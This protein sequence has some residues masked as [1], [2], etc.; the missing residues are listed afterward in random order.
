MKA[1]KIFSE[2]RY[3]AT[4]SF[5]SMTHSSKPFI[6]LATIFLANF[7]ANGLLRAQKPP[8]PPPT[9]NIKSIFPR[10]GQPGT[11]FEVTFQGKNLEH[12]HALWFDCGALRARFLRVEALQPEARPGEV[13]KR[14]KEKEGP[15]SYH[16][17]F[18]VEVGEGARIGAHAL[19][20][21]SSGGVSNPLV[22]QVNSEP[23]IL[24]QDGPHQ[25]PQQAQEIPFFP[26]VVNGRVAE[27][28]ELDYYSIRVSKGQDLLFEVLP[29]TG[30]LPTNFGNF[31]PRVLL[32]EPTGSWF[33]PHQPTWLEC[34]DES[35]FYLRKGRYTIQYLPRLIRRFDREG[36][37][38]LEVQAFEGQGSP[39]HTYQLRITLLEPSP[40]GGNPWTP[41]VLV[42]R[43][44]TDW[45]ERVFNRRL[46]PDRVLRLLSRTVSVQPPSE[47][48]SG[49]GAAE[50]GLADSASESA[51]GA[52]REAPAH[53]DFL[54]RLTLVREREP[55]DRAEQALEVELPLIVE[56]TIQ[57]PG[58]ADYFKFRAEAGKALA[59][60]V[61]APEL[62]PPHFNPRLAIQGAEGKEIFTNI[63]RV[64]GGDGDDWIK[65][66]QPKTVY[67]FEQTGEYF[68]RVSDLTARQYGARFRYRVLVRPRIP[69]VGR[70]VPT[71]FGSR[72]YD[73][74]EEDRI[75]LVPGGT[76][77]LN[78]VSSQEEG[79]DGEIILSVENLPPGVQVFP[80]AASP[81][82]INSQLGQIYE[83]RG[84]IHPEWYLPRRLVT[85]LVLTAAP[86]APVTPMPYF[87]RFTAR[88]ALQG[89]VGEA[90]SVYEMPLM[91]VQTSK[92]KS[93]SD[94]GGSGKE[95][96]H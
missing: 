6:F 88:P 54:P 26:V 62:T 70:V 74:R 8:E 10:G 81:R 82:E 24:E 44:D 36:T 93:T 31:T 28:G 61:E 78:V 76:R 75:N 32:Y 1:L 5:E 13:E 3:A 52:V 79:F 63:Y 87:I 12:A 48:E 9:P 53:G 83:K 11:R 69:H 64:L 35:I 46:E 34:R 33:D 65:I 85:P 55:N 18:Q 57:Q 58:D 56:G 95:A 37:Y 20:L 73:E 66:V 68:L 21:V 77:R 84:A 47:K 90:F 30:I 39:N 15:R 89:R 91:V 80:A 45:K 41:P 23:S 22:F 29:G 19:R 60:E 92:D 96:R 43:D 59:F 50:S 42:H 7:L 2:A 67:T 38:L 17:I 51:A 4:G 25:R 14:G 72:F 86:G 16:A 49:G 40:A 27:K 94:S 71:T